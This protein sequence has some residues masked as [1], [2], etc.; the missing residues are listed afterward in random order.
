[1]LRR[2]EAPPLEHRIKADKERA[3]KFALAFR[4]LEALLSFVLTLPFLGS[5]MEINRYLDNVTLSFVQL[6][7]LKAKFGIEEVHFLS[8][9]PTN[10]KTALTYL[11]QQGKMHRASKGPPEL[12]LNLASNKSDIERRV[13]ASIDKFAG[14]NSAHEHGEAAGVTMLTSLRL[15]RVGM[16]GLTPTLISMKS[17]LAAKNLPQLTLIIIE[18]IRL[19][20]A[21]VGRGITLIIVLCMILD[22]IQEL[23]ERSDGC[24]YVFIGAN[25]ESLIRVWSLPC[26]D[27]IETSKRDDGI[28]P[29]KDNQA[30]QRL[31][32]TAEKVKMDLSS[33]TQTNISFPFITAT[34]DGPKHIETTITRAK[35]EELCSDLLDRLKT[36][37][38][39]SLRPSVAIGLNVTQ[40]RVIY[41]LNERDGGS[42]LVSFWCSL[43]KCLFGFGMKGD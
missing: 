34:A 24:G 1:M 10:K 21:T 8:F 26:W 30:L 27:L 38:E 23:S 3:L 29:L 11:D 7:D 9:N 4:G 33:L 35:F 43:V 19:I 25:S 17:A 22:L 36:P 41:I 42:D 37:V 28:D 31:T 39:N 15:M 6:F 12:V 14:G 2:G 20:M 18:I 32:R 13:H 16:P 40:W 5:W